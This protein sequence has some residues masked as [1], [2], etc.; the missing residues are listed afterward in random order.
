MADA[1]GNYVDESLIDN[2]ADGA[3]TAQKQAVIDRMEEQIEKITHDLFY[4][5]DFDIKLDGTGKNRLFLGLKPDIISVT[6][7]KV[8]EVTLD[9]SWWSYDK[10]SVFL[11]LE[12]ASGQL[13]EK[14][15][16]LKQSQ[17][18]VLFPGGYDNIHCVGTY[19]HSACPEAIKKTAIIMCRDDNDS[20]LYS[21]YYKG[22]EHLGPYSYQSDEK[23]LTGIR[24]ADI[25]LRCYIKAKPLMR[26]I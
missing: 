19:G 23:P 25:L 8:L 7:I 15:W 16:L 22:Q 9:S 12:S 2:W 3:T 20:T 24:E 17:E 26:A 5:A 4:A 6:S 14:H 18:T 10:N 11:N 21:H 1:A 13:A